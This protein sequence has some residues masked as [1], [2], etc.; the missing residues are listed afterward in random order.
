MLGSYMGGKAELLRAAGL[1][2]RGEL[3]PVVDSTYPLAE[4]AQAHL[5]LESSDHF[6]KIVLIP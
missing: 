3:A 4:A 2:F 1:F 6:G 5:R